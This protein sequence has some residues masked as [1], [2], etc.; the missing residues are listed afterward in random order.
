M[1]NLDKIYK[2]N[3]LFIILIGITGFCFGLLNWESNLVDLFY[4]KYSKTFSN[5]ILYKNQF[6]PETKLCFYNLLSIRFLNFNN[7]CHLF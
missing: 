4:M 7:C 5:F 3:A 1:E 6:I 2:K